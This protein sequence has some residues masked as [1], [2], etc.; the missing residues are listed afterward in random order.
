MCTL[1]HIVYSLGTISSAAS[2]QTAVTSYVSVVSGIH[3]HVPP[4]ANSS[5]QMVPSSPATT[6]SPSQSTIIYTFIIIYFHLLIIADG[7]SVVGAVLGGVAAAAV[8]LCCILVIP[9]ICVWGRR[10]DTRSGIVHTHTC[11]CIFDVTDTIMLTFQVIWIL[12]LRF[13]TVLYV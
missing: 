4:I 7:T 12:T 11:M 10:K 3:V 8:L 9:I 1:I 6:N 5:T 2:D 13:V